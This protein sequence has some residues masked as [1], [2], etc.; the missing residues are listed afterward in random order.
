MVD[1]TLKYTLVVFAALNVLIAPF[2]GTF[3]ETI[4]DLALASVCITVAWLLHKPAGRIP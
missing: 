1:A 4:R 3:G 2:E